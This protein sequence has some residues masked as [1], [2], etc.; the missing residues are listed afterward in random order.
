MKKKKNG[1]EECSYKDTVRVSV[2]ITRTQ[3]YCN[4]KEA[5]ETSVLS[6]AVPGSCSS[7]MCKSLDSSFKQGLLTVVRLLNT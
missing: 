4:L 7:N 5:P 1:G 6:A 2:L 3:I